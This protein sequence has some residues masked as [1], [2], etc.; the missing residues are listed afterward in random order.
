MERDQEKVPI[1]SE[2]PV[3]GG[4]QGLL[5]TRRPG[6]CKRAEVPKEQIFSDLIV[7]QNSDSGPG[8]AF[9]PLGPGQALA[10]SGPQ[11]RPL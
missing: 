9:G 8:P 5:D 2:S 3:T 7:T 1:G 6:C 10:F 11:F 4:I